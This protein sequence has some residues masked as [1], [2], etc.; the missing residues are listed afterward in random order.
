MVDDTTPNGDIVSSIARPR[1]RAYLALED[2]LDLLEPHHRQ[3]CDRII[4]EQATALK[5]GPGSRHNHQAWAGGYL[6]HIVEGMNLIVVIYHTYNSLRP[7]GYSLS[8]ALFVFF[9]HDL[10]KL[11]KYRQNRSGEYEV[12]STLATKPQEREHREHQLEHFR[13][14]LTDEER[15]AFRYVEGEGTDYSS[16]GP[17]MNP[18]GCLCHIADVTSARHWP[19]HPIKNDPWRGSERYADPST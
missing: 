6:A 19:Q 17:R 7:V 9:I 5:T 4:H 2:L 3:A 12:V 14:T 11:S 10:E 1:A 8:S 18:L 15:I 13:I 16:K